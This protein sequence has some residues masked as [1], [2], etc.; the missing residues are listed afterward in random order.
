MVHRMIGAKMGTGGSSGYAYLTQA[1]ASHRVFKDLF[2]L[3]TFLVPRHELPPLPTELREK[4]SFNL[5]N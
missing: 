1:A 4:L 3:S 5:D 2:N